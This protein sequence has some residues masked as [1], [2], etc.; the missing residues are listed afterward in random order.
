[1]ASVL[2]LGGY[3]NFGKRICQALVA[4]G[5]SVII[6]GRRMERAEAL[7]TQLGPLAIARALQVPEGVPAAL[8]DL[9]PEVIV[10]T[11]GP[12]Q[13]Q[14]Y[15][16]AKAAIDARV[17]YVDLADGRAFVRGFGALDGAAKAAGVPLI[18]GASTVPALSDAVLSA[19]APHFAQLSALRYGI[20]PGQGAE[21]GLATTQG[22]LSYVGRPLAPFAH[23]QQPHYGWQQLYRQAYPTLGKRWMASCD[24][25]DLDV[26]PPRYGLRSIQFSAGLE[27]G[28]LHLTLW[29][30]GWLVRLGLPVPLVRLAKPML[31]AS[32]WFDRFGSRDGGMHLHMQGTRAEAPNEPLALDWFIEA[33][34]GHGPHIPTVPAI[35]LAER[36][37]RGERS[38]APG[39]YPCVGLI[40]LQA[41]LAELR[42]L[43]VKVFPPA[44]PGPDQPNAP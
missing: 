29:S 36:I 11:V 37:V 20:A 24:I 21:R 33:R 6:A 34:D 15:A 3:G 16:V 22:I 1:M 27:L 43:K 44:L 12:F 17:P 2:V 18:T 39:A 23:P 30:L 8:A 41:Y 9:Q 40:E 13:G 25:P 7:A 5:I 14:D 10:N 4:K 26:L 31:A 35:L 32:D 42:D 28:L 19:Y 38:L